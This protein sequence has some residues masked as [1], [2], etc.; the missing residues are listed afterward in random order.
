MEL[1]T[2]FLAHSMATFANA[3]ARL[4]FVMPRAVLNADQHQ[5]LIRRRYSKDARLELTAYWDL[6][7]VVPLFNVPSCVLFAKRANFPGSPDDKLPVMEW[8]GKLPNRDVNWSVA[9]KLLN[10][11]SAEG[12]VIY[13]GGRAALST[14]IGASVPSPPSKYLRVF[15]QGATI[16]PRSLYFVRVHEL[17]GNVEPD[18]TYWDETD[19]E[20]T[21]QAKKAYDHIRMSGLVEGRFIYTTA[22][23]R[24]LVPFALLTPVTIVLPIESKDGS[25]RI[26]NAEEL[27]SEGYREFGKWMQEAERCWNLKRKEKAGKQD[28][29]QWLD[30]Q[31]KLTRQQLK[32][33]Y[34][35]L[36]N[37]S[38][39]NVSAAF[40]DR[41]YQVAPFIVDVKLYYAAFSN[42][43][44]ADYVA[45][46]LNSDTVNVAIK[47]FQSAGL[48]GERDIH[49][50]VLN[51]DNAKHRQISD[52]GANAREEAANAVKSKE[53]P[54]KSSIARQRAFI[55]QFLKSEL[56][57]I[58][59]LVKVLLSS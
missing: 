18:S 33:R 44:E 30:Y 27:I 13:L 48:L 51:A 32:Q 47:P 56:A 59:T 26:L 42:R 55:R 28:L 9:Q 6:W 52:L 45:A 1:A 8:R 20:Q 34:L 12:R 22:I 21:K 57:D 19:P 17:K 24:H 39:M 4:A 50:K 7:D 53:F 54:A 2:V 58:D 40:F 23:S 36:Y 31:S 15:R 38:G 41:A 29:Y 16:V 35:V 5:N 11:E 25:L 43:Q 14:G 37:H 3:S 46:V 49:K 10:S